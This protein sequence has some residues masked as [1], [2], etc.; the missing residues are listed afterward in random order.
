MA[1]APPP[2]HYP[3]GPQVTV[4]FLEISKC[5][6]TVTI[7]K[8]IH[9]FLATLGLVAV[10]GFSLTGVSWGYYGYVGFSLQWPPLLTSIG[11]RS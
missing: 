1:H 4:G 11:S 10:C 8:K 7:L 9:L 3:S 6:L 5:L 2:H